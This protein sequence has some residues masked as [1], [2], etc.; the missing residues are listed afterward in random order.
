MVPLVHGWHVASHSQWFGP[1]AT[2]EPSRAKSQFPE[3]LR[4]GTTVFRATEVTEEVA[5]DSRAEVLDSAG[6]ARR[7]E[8]RCQ[9]ARSCR[10]RRVL[11]YQE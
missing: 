10:W 6:S 9:A 8:H 5:D 11:P 1:C 4:D 7:E 2:R 3:T